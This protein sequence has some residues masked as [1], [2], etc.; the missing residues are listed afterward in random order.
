MTAL[1]FIAILSFVTI[2]SGISQFFQ[3]IEPSILRETSKL[4]DFL[5][6]QVVIIGKVSR[7]KIPTIDGIEIGTPS[8]FSIHQ[9]YQ[10]SGVLEKFERTDEMV[11]EM[12]ADG[13]AH[14][15]AGAFYRIV[16]P[17]TREIVA[18]KPLQPIKPPD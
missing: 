3:K 17:E 16:D 13:I 1:V 9:V 4:D 8:G 6:K 14:N 15:G 5:G 2:E 10:A 12:N 7:T 11:K 18:I